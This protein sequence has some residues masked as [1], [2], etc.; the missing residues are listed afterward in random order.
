L[1]G[2]ESVA[3]VGDAMRAMTSQQAL[4]LAEEIVDVAELLR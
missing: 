3:E 2:F 4:S 1:L